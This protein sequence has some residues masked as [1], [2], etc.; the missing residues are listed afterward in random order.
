MTPR[1]LEDFDFQH[2]EI[3][4]SDERAEEEADEEIDEYLDA[5]EEAELSEQELDSLRHGYLERARK[6]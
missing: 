3:V 4:V 1:E 6:S 5:E 2:P